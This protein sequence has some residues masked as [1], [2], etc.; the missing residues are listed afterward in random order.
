MHPNRL[1]MSD[2][3]QSDAHRQLSLNAALETTVLLKN[4][5][6]MGMT[7]PITD[8]VSSACVSASE[9]LLKSVFHSG[10]VSLSL[11]LSLSLAPGCWSIHQ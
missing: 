3:V 5:I 10:L 4:N 8:A 6:T 7:L 9:L 1:N 2:F 11:S